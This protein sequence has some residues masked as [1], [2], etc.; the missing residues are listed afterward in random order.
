MTDGKTLMIRQAGSDLF[1]AR[2]HSIEPPS[3]GSIGMRSHTLL[4][5]GPDMPRD[6]LLAVLEQRGWTEH[7]ISRE[8]AIAMK[9][10]PE[11]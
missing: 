4:W 8:L 11:A 3:P 1:H 6:E 5:A 9:Q 10:E 2:E 7:E